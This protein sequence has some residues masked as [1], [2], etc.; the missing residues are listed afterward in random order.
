MQRR[1]FVTGS[2]AV[3]G[4]AGF[5]SLGR[6]RRGRVASC[7][8]CPPPRADW[9]ATGALEGRAPADPMSLTDEERI[10]VPVL[11]LPE[12]VRAGRPFD[13]VVQIGVRPHEMIAGH[14]I[15]WIEV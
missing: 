12:R 8:T 6:A 13:L 2:I 1:A 15:E 4:A 10:H 9:S 14:R 5:P 7:P 11:S 3:L